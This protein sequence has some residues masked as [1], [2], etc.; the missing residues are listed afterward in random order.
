MSK[1]I[2]LKKL[3]LDFEKKK[4]D[5]HLVGKSGNKLVFFFDPFQQ[6]DVQKILDKHD[7]PYV[8]GCKSFHVILD[9]V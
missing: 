4:L 1:K 8:M 2:D 7:L 5:V 6:P 9:G 3:F